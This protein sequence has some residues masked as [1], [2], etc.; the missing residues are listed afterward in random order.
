[1]DSLPT[2]Y[3]TYITYSTS[4]NYCISLVKFV[5]RVPKKFSLHNKFN[6]FLQW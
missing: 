4:T 6:L 3:D 2:E 1:M 5:L